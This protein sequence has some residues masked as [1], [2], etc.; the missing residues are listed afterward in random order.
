VAR[1]IHKKQQFTEVKIMQNNNRVLIIILAVV[2]VLFIAGCLVIAIGMGAFSTIA[3]T[4]SQATPA[5]YG[6]MPPDEQVEI[7]GPTRVDQIP[8]SIHDANVE[9][10]VGSPIPVDVVVV[11]EWPSL[12]AQLAQ[13]NMR[14]V[15]QTQIYIDLLATPTDPSCPPDLVGL[16]Y[17]LRIPLNMVEM[18]PGT[19]TVTI[20]G[21]QT[22]FDWPVQAEPQ[23]NT[24]DPLRMAY[25]GANG[26]VWLL[27]LPEGT[28]R[29]ITGDS[30]P[31]TE[32]GG[33]INYNEPR[34]SSDGLYLA[35]RRSVGTPISEG[36]QVEFGLWI[37]DLEKGES[38]LMYDKNPSGF[39]WQPG[40]HLLA[41]IPEL[42]RE[43][44]NVRNERPDAN[45][46]KGI[47]GYDANEG[48]TV[49][50]VAPERG[51]TL[52]SPV[53]SLDGRFLSF[54]EIL[55]MEGRGLFAYYDFTTGQYIAWNEPVGNYS[56]SPDGEHLAFDTLTY[57]ATGEERIYTREREGTAILPFSFEPDSGYV[58]QPS[59]SPQGN[60]IAYL[61]KLS[62]GENQL[63]TLIVQDYPSG[64]AYQLGVFENV[65]AF[66]WSPDG[67]RL[68]FS[69][70]RW[71]EQQI[72]LVNLLDESST[73]LTSGMQPSLSFVP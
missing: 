24:L 68:G 50:L 57:I 33:Y 36:M 65:Y 6:N 14:F 26:N 61:A 5:V 11:A 67:N 45:Y 39:N 62:E 59:F 3:T 56:W 55:Y 15:E 9:I 40:T 64:D 29:Q 49:E 58:I 31:Q 66:N 60:R 37:S 22:S 53:W 25:I 69:F 73:I 70:G 4:R 41:Y 42:E 18:P 51:Y 48:T 1:G 8:I 54:D 30:M 71:G 47:M 20:N 16:R 7:A 32:G 63:F 2:G 21:L 19:Y 13:V 23:T 52:Y 43:Y 17:G 28:P 12:C 34:L 27:D 72:A 46:A 44:F 35:Y 10:G 38:T